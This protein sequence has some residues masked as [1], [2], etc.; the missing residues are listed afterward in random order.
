[1]LIQEYQ[2]RWPHDFEA[3]KSV[4][5]SVLNETLCVIEHVGSTAVPQLA[6]KPIIDIDIV[7]TEQ[8]QFAVIKAGL[9]SLGYFHNGDQG[10]PGREVFKRGISGTTH[11]VLD[12][13]V[14]HLYVCM[15]GSAQLN[16][17]L[18]LRNYLRAHPE[19]RAVYQQMKYELAVEAKQ[20]R[21]RYA[22]LKEEKAN[23][24]IDAV[25]EKAKGEL[26]V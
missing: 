17:H 21:K 20:D 15:K 18:L 26:G 22:A 23:V 3:I 19:A 9:A 10:L 2:E 8:Q 1:M 24:F 14:H 5:H 4:L 12:T 25:L 7:Y 13:I 11:P 6:A 16:R